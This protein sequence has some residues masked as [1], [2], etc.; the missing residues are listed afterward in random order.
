MGEIRDGHGGEQKIEEKAEEIKEDPKANSKSNLNFFIVIGVI[1][2][3]F[4]AIFAIRIFLKPEKMTIEEMIVKTLQGDTNP[5]TNYMYDGYVFVKVEP[6]WY[7]QWQV[8]DTLFNIP[9]HYGP[10][11]L[12][13]IKAEGELDERFNTGHYYITF[14]PYGDDFAHVAV[15]AGEIGRNLVEG[16]GAKI[17]SACYKNHSV[18]EGKPIITCDNTNESVI[19]IKEADDAKIV[20]DGNCLVLQGEGEELLKVVDRVILQLYGIMK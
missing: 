7:T 14:D 5:E 3:L 6:L 8:E 16:L 1:I 10:L 17:S 9:L 18:C 13:D 2:I 4:A 12:E 15:A 19:Y 20:M 11:E